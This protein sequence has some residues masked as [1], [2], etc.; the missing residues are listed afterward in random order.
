MTSPVRD[1]TLIRSRLETDAYNPVLVEDLINGL[2]D[3][4]SVQEIV[5]LTFKALSD[6]VKSQ[7]ATIKELEN[8]LPTKASK[9]EISSCLSI[10]SSFS[11]LSRNISELKSCV[12][13]KMC[14]DDVYSIVEEKVSRADLQ[15]LLG[16]K[17]SYE[18]LRGSLSE[19][20]D[21]REVQSE[22]R[23]L[24]A[25]LE[26]MNEENYRKFSQCASKRDIQQLESL[27]DLKVS[28]EE[29]TE[30]LEEKAN[31]QSVANALHRKANKADID[32][33][34]SSKADQS[35]LHKFSETIKDLFSQLSLKPDKSE[36]SK[37]ISQ[38]CY[39][40]LDKQEFESTLSLVQGNQKD[41]ESRLASYITTL[42]SFSTNL[43]SK[44]E[45]LQNTLT[46]S[47]S[48]KADLRDLEK[49]QQSSSKKVDIDIIS[50]L[51][52]ELKDQGQCFKYECLNI[53][54]ALAERYSKL[55][56]NLRVFQGELAKV[57]ESVRIVS[58]NS[59]VSIEEGVKSVHH[60]T[61]NKLEE[62]RI[63]RQEL[64][65]VFREFN[66][67]KHLALDKSE[68]KKGLESKIDSRDLREFLDKTLR[69]VNRQ[70]QIT[71]D[72][73]RE[74]ILR[75][76]KELVLLI[77]KKPNVHEINSLFIENKQHKGFLEAEREYKTRD[78]SVEMVSREISR[79]KYE[80][81]DKLTLFIHDQNQ[82]NEMLCAENCVARWLWRSGNTKGIAV[83]WE[84][85]S[86]NTCPENF[87]WEAGGTSIVSVASGLYEVF[88][89]VFSWKQPKV[90][91]LVNGEPVIMDYSSIGK[92]WGRHSDGS[93]MAASVHDYI[94]LPVKA[95]ISLTFTGETG[96][97]GVLGL[98]KL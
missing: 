44:I 35:E 79:T 89:A 36:V 94:T 17:A 42:E 55:E 65:K 28:K 63:L 81:E 45:D 49:L 9:S 10:K 54:E 27:L 52:S 12:D 39:K 60:Y 30:Q 38:E 90:E 58:E 77:D 14:V 3:W 20:A 72:D 37:C 84:Y 2:N 76:E 97:E 4:R 46:S 82:L 85:E 53:Q 23:A 8:Q 75:K 32:P 48:R 41:S 88:F 62:V 21:L 34:L 29:L 86:V 59:R 73:L 92:A 31:K 95:R 91:L 56:Q 67:V 71:A 93:V 1:Y 43:K 26:E 22:I 57:N 98:K 11:E 87:L 19:K 83:P 6:V 5:R 74:L 70:M 66:E 47:L 25:V 16:S 64:E 15:Y 68:L 80:L 78:S 24:R 33:I 61:G 96:A 51:Q 13:T 50:S 40:K 18:E 69:D 7:G